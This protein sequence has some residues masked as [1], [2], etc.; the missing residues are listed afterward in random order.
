MLNP[1]TCV[2]GMEKG[3]VVA[4]TQQRG[5]G[6]GSSDNWGAAGGSFEDGEPPSPDYS[7]SYGIHTW[8]R[9]HDTASHRKSILLYVNV[10]KINWKTYR[11]TF[12]N[13]SVFNQS[14]WGSRC[15]SHIS[16]NWFPLFK[17]PFAPM[18]SVLSPQASL[19]FGP[20]QWQQ[21]PACGSPP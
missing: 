20:A 6:G 2:T 19:L 8:I 21:G 18:L 15:L 14:P 13:H 5:G 3:P 10:K 9:T 17:A 16:C 12:S 11:E 1:C 7:G 4:K